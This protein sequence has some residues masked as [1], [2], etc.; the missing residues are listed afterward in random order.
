MG[1]Y[2]DFSFQIWPGDE[3]N[4]RA[5][6]SSGEHSRDHWVKFDE[7]E[8]C[9]QF[10]QFLIVGATNEE[11]EVIADA[12][13]A[14]LQRIRSERSVKATI[15][16]EDDECESGVALTQAINEVLA[17]DAAETQRAAE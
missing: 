9:R 15:I 10:M 12:I 16:A 4:V 11:I 13:N 7:G 5:S 3:V 8:R 6:T 1:I 2:K 14:P 17:E